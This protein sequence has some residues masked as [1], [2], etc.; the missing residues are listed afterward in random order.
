[1]RARPSLS[2]VA[3]ILACAGNQA[4]RPFTSDGCTLYPDGKPGDPRLWCDCCFAH[5]ITYWR[6]GTE[7]ERLRADEALRACMLERTGD[8]R[9]ATMMYEGVRL[10]G[11][12]A[13]PD[14]YRWGYGWPYGRGYRP[15]SEP[16]RAQS[17]ERLAEYFRATP[18]GYCGRK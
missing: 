5:D 10:G 13:F 6:G 16:E 18:R 8:P 9:I 14:W 1:M 12:P 3:L 11:S 2:L 7:A 17:K 4:I 15:L